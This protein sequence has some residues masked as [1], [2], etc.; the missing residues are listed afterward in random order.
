MDSGAARYVELYQQISGS[1]AMGYR[2]NLLTVSAPSGAGKTS[3]VK[4]LV[5]RD[6]QV[7]ASVSYTTR[8]KR[9][10][11]KHGVNYHFV[12]QQTFRAMLEADEFLEYAQ[13]FTHFY[14]TSAQS[15]KAML[16]RPRCHL[17]NRLAGS[18]AGK[19]AHSRGQRSLHRAAVK[20]GIARSSAQP[21]P[22]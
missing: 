16:D 15:V 9:P 19:A 2:G 3:L 18:T 10:G 8:S 17:R 14:G 13:V 1:G 12:D 22:R 20:A 7:H 4:A 21:R 6:P 5:E 11:E